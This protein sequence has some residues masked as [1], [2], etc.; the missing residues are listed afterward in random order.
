MEDG[1]FVRDAI[2]ES[3]TWKA[4]TALGLNSASWGAPHSPRGGLA[5][6]LRSSVS[7]FKRP[8]RRRGASLARPRDGYLALPLASTGSADLLVCR[9]WECSPAL[10]SLAVSNG[11][12]S[13]GSFPSSARRVGGK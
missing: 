12:P 7:E 4:E 10:G 9:V 13:S 8:E 11:C 6:S 2:S 3:H 5:S 1:V